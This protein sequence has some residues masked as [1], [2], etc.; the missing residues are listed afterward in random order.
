MV[1]LSMLPLAFA[2]CAGV[3]TALSEGYKN[4]TIG[5]PGGLQVTVFLP[6]DSPDERAYYTGTRF[7]W[8]TQIGNFVVGE[9]V[10]YGH[11]F[12]RGNPH[13]PSNPEAAVGI[14]EE[15]G[16]GDGG[17]KCGASPLDNAGEGSDNGVLGYAQVKQGE[18]FLKIG[19][20]KLIKDLADDS[21][22]TPF[23]SWEFA[24]HPVWQV[25]SDEN[26]VYMSQEM[27]VDLTGNDPAGDI[28][29]YRKTVMLRLLNNK[30]YQV[31]SLHNC[32]SQAFATPHYS[33]NFLSVDRQ[34]IGPPWKLQV[35]PDVTSRLPDPGW[36]RPISEYFSPEE[37]RTDVLEAHTVLEAGNANKAVFVGDQNKDVS[38][39]WKAWYGEL[40]ITSEQRQ[41]KAGN[42]AP[43]YAFNVYNEHTAMC[44]EPFQLISLAPGEW[45]DWGRTLSFN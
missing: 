30:F 34:P 18:A 14:A 40:E 23:R 38:N 6:P 13:D 19:V 11:D 33:H 42:Q 32:G 41:W 12:W 21:E 15:F 1:R 8:S 7:D 26:S 5:A 3:A 20:G 43:L 35:V 10:V 28:W 24:E 44:P 36:A 39:M 31:S 45:I 4:V 25:E 9:H 17:T 37:N 16:C 27:K 2:A 22:Y 29:C